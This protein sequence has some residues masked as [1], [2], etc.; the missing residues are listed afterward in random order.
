MRSH[1]R[2]KKGSPS[3]RGVH[4][5]VDA[6]VDSAVRRALALVAD[7]L[8][9]VVEA[10]D[11]LDGGSGRGLAIATAM[12]R[13]TGFDLREQRLILM[14]DIPPAP[15]SLRVKAPESIPAGR[16]GLPALP[17]RASRLHRISRPTHALN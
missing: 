1:Q 4:A 6:M 2:G 5:R 3:G 16:L 12:A 11:R 17:E 13:L 7:R 15:V 10:V 14:T 8:N 9:K